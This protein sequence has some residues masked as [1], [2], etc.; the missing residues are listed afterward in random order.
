MP[1][2]HEG[3]GVSEEIVKEFIELLHKPYEPV[4]PVLPKPVNLRSVN[5]SPYDASGRPKID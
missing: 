4:K 2:N 1:R 3:Q 5:S